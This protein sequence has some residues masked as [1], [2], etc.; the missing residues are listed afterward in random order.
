[1]ERQVA[2]KVVLEAATAETSAAAALRDGGGDG[3][4]VYDCD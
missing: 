1:V 4:D 3:D 2:E